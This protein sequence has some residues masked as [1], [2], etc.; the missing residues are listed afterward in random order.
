MIDTNH[1]TKPSRIVLGTD[2]MAAFPNSSKWNILPAKGANILLKKAIDL[3]INA[4]DTARVYSSEGILGQFIRANNIDREKL[5]IISKG[6]HPGIISKNPK[7]ITNIRLHKQLETSLKTLNTEYLDVFL[8]HYDDPNVPTDELVEWCLKLLKTNKIRKIGYS[9]FSLDR[10][11]KI[12]KALESEGCIPWV[13]TEFNCLPVQNARWQGA[14]NIS[15]NF[16]YLK[17]LKEKNIPLLAYSPLGR[18]YLKKKTDQIKK[19]DP[20]QKFIKLYIQKTTG[21]KKNQ[22]SPEMSQQIAKLRTL[23]E[24]YKVSPVNIALQ[25]VLR[26][27]NNFYPVLGTSNPNHLEESL[28]ALEVNLSAEDFADL[29]P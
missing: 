9:N 29:S 17:F 14:Q 16:E 19:E 6:G 3:G 27:S 5:F 18:G 23:S 20:L 11:I 4:F 21:E 12:T 1:T 24:K 26:F 8:I 22:D 7:P 13:S 2:W 28:Q 25:Y 15:Q 10:L